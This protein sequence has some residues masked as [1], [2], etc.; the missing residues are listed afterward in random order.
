MSGEDIIP[1]DLVIHLKGGGFFFLRATVDIATNLVNSYIDFIK[2]SEE[3]LKNSDV[4]KPILF[5]RWYK[6]E[7]GPD[8][9]PQLILFSQISG[10]QTNF[11]QISSTDK[12]ANYAEK[13]S[14][15]IDKGEG[16]KKEE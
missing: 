4:N 13:M 6:L 1:V 16:W 14:K 3:M 15:E 11:H 7:S 10:I 8:K 9:L 2:K 12:I 5:E